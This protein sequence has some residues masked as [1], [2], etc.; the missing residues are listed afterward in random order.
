M[1]SFLQT[2]EWL[3]FQES[4]GRKVWRFDDGKVVANI[5]QHDL[6]FGMNYLYIPHG[7]EIHLENISGG[8]RNEL[9]S[10]IS[11]LKKIAKE[12]KSI[13]IKIEPLQDSVI[14]LLYG[15]G[16]RK[17][18]KEIQPHRSVIMDLDKSEEEMLAAMHHKTR[19]NIKVAEKNEL[20]LVFR[21]DVDTFWNLLKQTAKRD[22]FSTHQKSYY[23][24]LCST[25]GL[26][27]ETAFIEHNDKSVV[28]AIW[29][30]SGDTAY[31]LHGAM[32]RDPAYRPMMAP[33]LMQ[34]ELI[35]T[36][37][38]YGMKYY[39][40]WGIDANRYPGVTRFKLG[41]GGRQVEYPGAFD[42][43]IRG[44]WFMMYKILR[45]IL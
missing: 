22:N 15:A 25:E 21:K 8:L 12:E 24:K 26:M 19:Y 28:G 13:F 32:D 7:P 6:P 30:A 14:E 36:A 2:K 45:K 31:Y 34:W 5:I 35:K 4:A 18:S 43:S 33:Y 3:N 10:F 17:S 27:C 42:M 20:K 39:D 23:E 41:W 1:K 11:Y 38:K 29:L 37:K 40:F 9:E 44:F 16:F